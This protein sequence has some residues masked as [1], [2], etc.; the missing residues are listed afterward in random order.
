MVKLPPSCISASRL[1]RNKI[2][3]ATP[4]CLGSNVSMVLTVTLPAGTGSQKYKMA[5]EENVVSRISACIHDSNEIPT[6]S[7]VFFSS[8]GNTGSLSGETVRCLGMSKIKDGGR[9]PEV[10]I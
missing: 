7:H 9:L 10:E 8:T 4:M 3:T 6:Q 5:A 1:V 2:P